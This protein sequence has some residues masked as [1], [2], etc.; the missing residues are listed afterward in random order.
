MEGVKTSQ[1]ARLL[2]LLL[3]ILI[4]GVLGQS[5]VIDSYV[6]GNF[7]QLEDNQVRAS[8]RL[9]RLWLDNFVQPLEATALT[10]S[11]WPAPPARE[12]WPARVIAAAQNRGATVDAAMRLKPGGV[13]DR[14]FAIGAR[15]EPGPLDDFTAE[16][17]RRHTTAAAAA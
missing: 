9:I 2:A 14:S 16:Y 1:R 17:L 11:A 10:A 5:Y 7:R 12:D 13:A 8:A 15:G 4:L 6:L 3:G